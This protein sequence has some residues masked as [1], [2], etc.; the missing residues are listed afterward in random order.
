MSALDKLVR[1]KMSKNL[2]HYHEPCAVDVLRA[3]AIAGM[4]HPAHWSLY[5]LKY[6]NDYDEISTSKAIFTRWAGASMHRRGL[7]PRRA[8]RMGAQILAA[9]VDDTCESCHGQRYKVIE[10]T[11][12]L[13]INVCG[14]CKGLGTN[15]IRGGPEG[16]VIKD[17]M[18]RA[19]DAVSL[20]CN[21]VENKLRY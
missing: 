14:L 20:I 3:S 2:R 18:E 1:A 4:H 9:W 15:P 7:D 11:P 10:N 12:T 8:S 17:V 13:S 5:R 19:D 16:D 21:I 6:L